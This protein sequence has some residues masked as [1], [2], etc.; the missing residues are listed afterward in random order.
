MRRFHEIDVEYEPSRQDTPTRVVLES[1]VRRVFEIAVYGDLVE[2]D[3]SLGPVTLHRVPR[4]PEPVASLAAGSLVAPMPG[5]VVR[6]GVDVGDRVRKGQ[7][8]LWIEAM[9]MEH[10]IEAPADGVVTS[11]NA[12]VS[13]QVEVGAVLAVVEEEQR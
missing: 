8:V 7:T 9:K 6:L 5:T 2:V 3:S 10:R 1:A 12:S 11:L 4:F 13:Q